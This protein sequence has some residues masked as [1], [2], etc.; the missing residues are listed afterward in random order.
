MISDIRFGEDNG[1][2]ARPLLSKKEL[3]RRETELEKNGHKILAVVEGTCFD[4]TMTL[5]LEPMGSGE[6]SKNALRAE[7]THRVATG[8]GT[9]VAILDHMFDAEDPSLKDR[10]VKPGSVLEGAPV[11]DPETSA[12]HGTWMAEDL[13]RIAPGVQIMPVRFCGRGRYGDPDL[14]I[15]GIK[16]AVENGADIVSISHQ[17]IPEEKQEDFDRAVEKAVERGV[18]VVYIH[19]RGRRKDVVVT[20]PIEFAPFYKGEENIHVIGT[21]FIKN[22]SFPYTWG[23]SPTAPIVSG[24]IAMMKEVNPGL[25]PVEIRKILLNSGRPISSDCQILDAFQAVKNSRR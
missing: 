9:V 7:K 3:L 24:V 23:G 18:T 20:K 25:K 15:A 21:N 4:A 19:Y 12:G 5:G 1:F 22:S 13:V 2:W 16:Y 17:P 14:Y 10:T 8:R 6:W 11:F